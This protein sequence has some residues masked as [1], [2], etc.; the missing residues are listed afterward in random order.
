MSGKPIGDLNGPWALLLK[1]T[2]VCVPVFGSVFIAVAIPWVRWQ[3]ETAYRS[4]ET[5]VIV[6]E[7]VDSCTSINKRFADLPP[8]EWRDRV[9]LLETDSRQN[10]QDHSDIKIS[11]EQIKAK[12]GV[13]TAGIVN[14]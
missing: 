9:K 2:L 6:D 12:L 7:L 10:L 4:E 5:R 1:I 11:L 3:T 13:G 8:I 14:Q